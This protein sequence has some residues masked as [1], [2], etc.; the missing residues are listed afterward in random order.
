M[1]HKK[2]KSGMPVIILLLG[3]AL[4]VVGSPEFYSQK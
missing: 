3:V 1:K 2:N 4:I